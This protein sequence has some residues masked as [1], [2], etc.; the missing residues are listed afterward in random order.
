MTEASSII[1]TRGC[2]CVEYFPQV[3][4]NEMKIDPIRDIDY[5]AVA[6]SFWRLRAGCL[7]LLFRIILHK[8][9]T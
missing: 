7:R 2:C 9:E 1:Q 8:L 6:L 3:P 5:V 4:Y